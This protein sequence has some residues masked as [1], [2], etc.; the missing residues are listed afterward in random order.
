MP[1]HDIVAIGSSAGGIEALKK[2]FAEL[3]PDLP[4]AFLVVQ[5]VGEVSILPD[6]LGSVGRYPARHPEDREVPKPGIIYIAPPSR[7]LQLEDGMLRLVRGPRENTF[8]PSVDV[9]FRS[10]A[11]DC[12]PR[13]IGVVLTGYL[14][15]G[16]AGLQAIKQRGGIA[17]IQDP[18]DAEYPSMPMTALREVDADRCLRLA[19]M[20]A[21]L[22]EA[23]RQPV[24]EIKE[25]PVSRQLELETDISKQD[26]DRGQ[27][28]AAVETLGDRTEL[29][30]PDCSG[31]LWQVRGPGPLRFRCHTGHAYTAE[32]FLASQ[33]TAL[34][35][36]LRSALRLMEEK[37]SFLQRMRER[38]KASGAG[39]SVLRY[40]ERASRLESEARQIRRLLKESVAV[41]SQAGEVI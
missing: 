7:H 31:G 22:A 29:S 25:Y 13:A 1:G 16:A 4:A 35:G 23:I 3:P 6:I 34:E 36:A 32:A 39:E 30:C 37:Y 24:T 28:M 14:G 10:V 2:L 38:T 19:E 41:D 27:M 20:P 8:R 12:G 21:Y 9:L 17:V 33:G 18:M 26:M 11:R 15:D 40:E 5:H